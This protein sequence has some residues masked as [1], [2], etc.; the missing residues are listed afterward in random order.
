M[1]G[2]GP[3]EELKVEYGLTKE[4]GSVDIELLVIILLELRER[5]IELEEKNDTD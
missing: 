4:D 2:Y 3:V 5:I 1:S